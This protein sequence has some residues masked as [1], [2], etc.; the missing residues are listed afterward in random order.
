[1]KL[2]NIFILLIILVMALLIV[3]CG[4]ESTDTTTVNNEKPTLKTNAQLFDTVVH[5]FGSK[6]F[7]NLYT[8]TSNN[9]QELM[10]EDAFLSIFDDISRIS[11]ELRIISDKTSKTENGIEYFSATLRFDNIDLELNV[12]IANAEISAI[13]YNVS[14]IR[15]FEIEYTDDVTERYFVLENDGYKLNAVYTYVNDGKEHPAVLLIPGSGQ[16][17]YNETIG[18]HKPFEDIALALADEGICSLRMDKRTLNYASSFKITDGLNEEYLSDCSKGIEYLSNNHKNIY[19]FGHSLGGQIAAEL[20]ARNTKI[21]GLILFNSSA[22]HLADIMKDQY[23]RVD[24]PN[25]DTYI[26]YANTVKEMSE[27]SAQGLYYYGASDYYWT[28]YNKLD[29]VESIID[30]DKNTLI[31]NSTYDKQSFNADIELWQN[32]FEGNEKVKINIYDDISHYGYKMDTSD[33]SNLYIEADF[34]KEII[35]CIYDFIKEE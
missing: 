22:R 7:D 25:S 14:F 18:I 35:S 6:K 1:M 23:I 11:G 5:S 32:S 8:Y 30:F 31:I 10:D 15:T 17:D 33:V 13:S 16:S 34:P 26:R 2:K 28:S 9:F 3:S 24:Y 27:S 19:L 4:S 12:G 20:S 21:E 29:T